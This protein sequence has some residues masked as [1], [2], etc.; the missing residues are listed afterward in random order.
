MESNEK[1]QILAMCERL[2]GM[3]ILQLAEGQFAGKE[4]NSIIVGEFKLAEFDNL[5]H[6]A[7]AQLV[8]EMSKGNWRFLPAN[9]SAP[10]FNLYAQLQALYNQANA[11]G[12]SYM[13][14][15][16]LLL[17]QYEIQNGFWDRSKIKLRS[18]EEIDFHKVKAELGL[19]EADLKIKVK[20]IDKLKQQL[21]TATA[22]ADNLYTVKQ[23]EFVSL[24]DNL[25]QANRSLQTIRDNEV[26]IAGLSGKLTTTFDQLNTQAASTQKY[27]E[28]E[29]SNYADLLTDTSALQQENK[30][31]VE[32]LD[33]YEGAF[34][35]ILNSAKEKEEEI[36]SQREAI[37]EL[38]GFAADAALG[39]VFGRRGKQ[40]RW[41]V[42]TWGIASIVAVAGAAYWVIFIF[43]HYG[44][45]QLAVK[46]DQ[47]S[48]SASWLMLVINVLRTSPAFVL[49]YFCLGQY[50]KERNLQEEYAFKSAVSMTI[51]AYAAMITTEQEKMQLLMSTVQGV[52]VPPAFANQS[53]LFS[54]RSKHL[55]ES[56][57]SAV[58]ALKEVKD[59]VS[60]I[61][62]PTKS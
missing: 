40:L 33:T 49:V 11:G 23:A 51:T 10:P 52:Y 18:I 7:V 60:D 38:R 19:I 56:G 2:R 29:R 22:K 42:L 3:D 25:N 8:A 34:N 62:K 30:Q 43:N 55:A 44:G 37:T 9:G 54:V 12:L 31:L 26:A 46:A 20:E 6:R 50:T 14:G 36:L 24:T 15:P 53:Q 59:I 21:T 27:I 32:H 1:D 41:T 48:Y 4:L 35:T 28:Q 57:K 17:I 39:G 58:E 47:V 13:L 16:L 61:T 5:F 45:F